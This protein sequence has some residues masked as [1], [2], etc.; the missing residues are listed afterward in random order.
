MENGNEKKNEVRRID[1]K[2]KRE[3]RTSSGGI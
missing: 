3:E 2:R 1:R